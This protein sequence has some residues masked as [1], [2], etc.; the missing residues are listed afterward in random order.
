MDNFIIAFYIVSWIVY[1]CGWFESTRKGFDK[2]NPIIPY[3]VRI[4]AFFGVVTSVVG[5]FV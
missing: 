5:I 4:L 1:I 2:K 3:W